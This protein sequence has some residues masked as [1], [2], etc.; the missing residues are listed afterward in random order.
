LNFE[1][2]LLENFQ[3]IMDPFTNEKITPIIPNIP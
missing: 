2:I 3:D 1:M